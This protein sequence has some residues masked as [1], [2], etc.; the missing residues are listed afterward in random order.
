MVKGRQK[1]SIIVAVWFVLTEVWNI[2]SVF[3]PIQHVTSFSYMALAVFWTVSLGKEIVEPYI[4]RSLQTGGLMLFLLFVLRFFRYSLDTPQEV[5]YRL[6]WYAYYI[7]IIT[8]PVLSFG[9]G[10]NIGGGDSVRPVSRGISDFANRKDLR[11]NKKVSLV[12]MGL[13]FLLIL[14]Y[15]TNDF[16]ELAM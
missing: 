16:H 5:V 3:T 4:R 9:A 7:P 10:I 1:T 6:L 14:L 12:L 2:V 13:S 8:L 11:R 15:L